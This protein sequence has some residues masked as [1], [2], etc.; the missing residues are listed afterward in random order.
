MSSTSSRRL[1]LL[2]HGRTEWNHAGRVQG[3]TDV[4]LD[5]EGRA[6]ASRVAVEMAKLDPTVLWS[7]DLLRA[8]RT[9]EALADVTGLPLVLDARLREFGLGEREGMTH[10]EYAAAAPEEF[11]L[12]RHG[13]YDSAPGAEQTDAVRDRMREVLRALLETIGPGETVIAVS[14]G[15]AIRVA[16]GALLGWPDDQFHTL[17]GLENCGWV[18][19]EEHSEID[20][21]RLGAYNRTV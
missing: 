11:N 15:A 20:G 12:F 16:T 6:Q 9:A 1:V 21:L 17:R 14:H 5:D 7:S 3:Q 8:R 4:D 13:Y 18:V 19:L 10:A 2:R